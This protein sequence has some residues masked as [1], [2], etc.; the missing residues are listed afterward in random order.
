M[1]QAG[2]LQKKGLRNGK[3]LFNS[4]I[5]ALPISNIGFEVVREALSQLLPL[6]LVFE[7]SFLTARTSIRT[8]WPLEFVSAEAANVLD[9]LF[10]D[11]LLNEELMRI[12]ATNNY[13][14]LGTRNG[15]KKCPNMSNL[16]PKLAGKTDAQD[17]KISIFRIITPL[18]GIAVGKSLLYNLAFD[19]RAAR[20]V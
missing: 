10:H 3:A 19:T 20:E 8:T 7:L 16:P 6:C 18:L 13:Y 14:T 9:F 4:I 11:S 15:S 17:Y 2:I 1:E 5:P 12:Y